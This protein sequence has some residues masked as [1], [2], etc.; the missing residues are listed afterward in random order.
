LGLRLEHPLFRRQ[1]L[2]LELFRTDSSGYLGSAENELRV[3]VDYAL[4]QALKFSLGWQRL[5]RKNKDPQNAL[6]DYNA[7]SLLAEFGLRF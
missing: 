7:N 3:G 1:T 2:F 5:S 4:T 6:Y